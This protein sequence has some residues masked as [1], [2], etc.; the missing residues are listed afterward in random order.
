MEKRDAQGKL[1]KSV[2]WR[3]EPTPPLHETTPG[4]IR[5]H[6]SV[7]ENEQYKDEGVGKVRTKR[8]ISKISLDKIG[9]H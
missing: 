5:D 1:E 2:K 8:P 6:H 3:E 7:A 9:L 4:G